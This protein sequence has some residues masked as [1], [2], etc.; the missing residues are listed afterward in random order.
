LNR[1]GVPL[2]AVALE[3]PEYDPEALAALAQRSGGRTASVTESVE[4]TAI[5]EEIAQE[6]RNVYT[7]TYTSLE[8]VRPSSSTY[9]LSVSVGRN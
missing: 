8:P 3:S 5:F 7:V 4:F 2:Y 9:E 6:L 1:P